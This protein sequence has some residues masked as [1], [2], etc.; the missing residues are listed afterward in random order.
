MKNAGMAGAVALVGIGL[1]SIGLSNFANRA[2]AV[3]A[4]S[5]PMPMSQGTCQTIELLDPEL[6][7]FDLGCEELSWPKVQL[8]TEDVLGIG[9]PQWIA[10]PRLDY[11][12]LTNLKIL[13]REGAFEPTIDFLSLK[14]AEAGLSTKQVLGAAWIDVDK[15]GRTDLVMIGSALRGGNLAVWLRNIYDSPA[16]LPADLNHDGRVDG[17]DL[18]TLFVQWT[19]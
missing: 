18:G 19:G 7:P 9:E 2:Q 11:G 1:L 4:T 3:P 14:W 12:S 8:V 6:R 17:E 16:R 15:D 10:L 5:V 13:T